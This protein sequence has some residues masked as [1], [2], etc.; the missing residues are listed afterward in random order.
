MER[1]ARLAAA[2]ELA[3]QVCPAQLG[4]YQSAVQ[5][6]QDAN[7]NIATARQL[8]ATDPDLQKARQD[9]RQAFDAQAIWTNPLVACNQLVGQLAWQMG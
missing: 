7:R 6:R 9:T 1:H 2:A 8:G 3:V 5:A 4:G